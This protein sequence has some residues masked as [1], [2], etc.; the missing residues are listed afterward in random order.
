[1]RLIDADRLNEQFDRWADMSP[2]M[3]ELASLFKQIVSIQPTV[4]QEERDEEV[5]K[6]DD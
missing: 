2:E 4:K 5:Q 6:W 3:F 1:M